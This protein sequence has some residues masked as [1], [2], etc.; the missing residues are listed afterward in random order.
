MQQQQ[1]RLPSPPPEKQVVD[2]FDN[3]PTQRDLRPP[4]FDRGRLIPDEEM[5]TMPY[6]PVTTPDEV[7]FA[8]ETKR[9]P[10]APEL[11]REEV[12]GE[13]HVGLSDEP[14]VSSLPNPIPDSGP[15]TIVG[16]PDFRDPLTS[17]L[18]AHPRTVPRQP[19]AV[20]RDEP[21]ARNPA[22]PARVRSESWADVRIV[23]KAEAG[24]LFPQIPSNAVPVPLTDTSATFN[25]YRSRLNAT[26]ARDLRQIRDTA[27]KY[28]VDPDDPV[29][30]IDDLGH[31]YLRQRALWRKAPSEDFED[32][33]ENLIRTAEKNEKK[34][35]DELLDS[36]DD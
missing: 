21:P 4:P 26:S 17:R 14:P 11:E 10:K 28:N 9:Y 18:H 20:I 6:T 34:I 15:V 30:S 19:P 1:T 5:P 7:A 32:M 36:L 2:S 24:T 22:S 27:R 12:S 25:A 13:F 29:F 33:L 16:A 3:E 35:M 31:V 23:D 8:A